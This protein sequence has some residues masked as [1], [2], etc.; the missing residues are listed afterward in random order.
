MERREEVDFF[1]W[2]THVKQQSQPLYSSILLF[3]FA[4]Q[5]RELS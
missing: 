1:A 4:P 5:K 3:H 2:L